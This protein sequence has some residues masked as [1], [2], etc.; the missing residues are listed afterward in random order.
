[1]DWKIHA[2]DEL[3][4][5]FTPLTQINKSTFKDL[6]VVADWDLPCNDIPI[7]SYPARQF[8]PNEAPPL[9]LGDYLYCIT[10]VCQVSKFDLNTGKAATDA[11]GKAIVYDPQLWKSLP[12]EMFGFLHRGLAYWQSSD[13]QDEHLL[14]TQNDGRLV[15]LELKT[16]IPKKSFGHQGV[17]NVHRDDRHRN[18]PYRLS[19][20]SP[21]MV[22]ADTIIVGA[23]Y[24]DS[25]NEP[26]PPQGDVKAFDAKTG[27]HKWTFK[28]IPNE[29]TVN[30]NPH[31]IDEQWGSTHAQDAGHANVWTTMSADENLG[32]VYLPVSGPFND[33]YGGNRHGDN[34][35]SQCLCAVKISDGTIAWHQ[36]LIHHDVWDYDLPAAPLLVNIK[37]EGNTRKLVVQVTKQAFSFV[38]DRETGDPEWPIEEKA[39][40]DGINKVGNERLSATQPFPLKPAAFDQQGIH[41]AQYTDQLGARQDANVL[42][43]TES[44]KSQT[45]DVIDQ[46][47]YGE[48]FTPPS[49]IDGPTRGTLQIPGY[50]GG[51]SWA[52]ACVNPE[53]GKFFVSSV[54]YP[55]INAVKKYPGKSGQNYFSA[56]PDTWGLKDK[57]NNAYTLPITLPP[58]G[59]ITCIDLHTGDHAWDEPAPV[60]KGPKEDLISA[61]Q[62]DDEK[63]SLRQQ[64]E[65][66]D[67]GWPL[68]T[69][70]LSSPDLL[71]AAQESKRTP[72]GVNND[73]GTIV[74]MLTGHEDPAEAPSLRAFDP[75]TGVLHGKVDLRQHAQ[76]SLSS[77]EHDGV[78]Y[79]AVPT[80]GFNQPAKIE[81]L[82]L[83]G[84]KRNEGKVTATSPVIWKKHHPRYQ[85]AVF[86]G[87]SRF[88]GVEPKSGAFQAPESMVFL[89]EFDEHGNMSPSYKAGYRKIENGDFKT[90]YKMFLSIAEPNEAAS[91][92]AAQTGKPSTMHIQGTEDTSRLAQGKPTEVYPDSTAWNGHLDVWNSVVGKGY[93]AWQYVNFYG[94]PSERLK[95]YPFND[96][97]SPDVISGRNIFI[98]GFGHELENSIVR[99]M[100]YSI[101]EPAGKGKRI[102][103]MRSSVLLL[104][105]SEY[106]DSEFEYFTDPD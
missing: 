45:L 106:S 21:P 29:C 34:R 17:I 80:G 69:H 84:S 30:G 57:A 20:T 98:N 79:I 11:N 89:R 14:V 9:K 87:H 77:F 12:P 5:R 105:S 8:G 104:E 96:L 59:R 7:A 83:K 64:L 47:V 42:N 43:L 65:G 10:P 62:P 32:L 50:I 48:L 85:R 56:G 66:K 86:T 55:M 41:P 99:T 27:V 78:Q 90:D 49:E 31:S 63:Q 76:G 93:A 91:S 39:V 16:L 36:Q 35:Y 23:A 101:D 51:A 2:G 19:I 100:S 60:G 28:T 73:A 71:F 54:T 13:K 37:K 24:P 70:L 81:L 92:S 82:A 75:D 68:R 58:W 38:F 97:I 72:I 67:L 88:C 33:S 26:H 95:S 6:E 4:Q 15:A 18:Q 102:I 52:G 61:I 103:L 3:A 25:A 94:R 53:T 44:L 46:Y 22:C 74:Y 1:M 40:P